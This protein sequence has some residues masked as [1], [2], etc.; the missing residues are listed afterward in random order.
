MLGMKLFASGLLWVFLAGASLSAVAQSQNPSL[1]SAVA[2]RQVNVVP[3]LSGEPDLVTGVVR[4]TASST[5][6]YS[7]MCGIA[8]QNGASRESV[9]WFADIVDM[10][11][12]KLLAPMNRHAY[13]AVDMLQVE[14]L[15]YVQPSRLA[16]QQDKLVRLC[17]VLRYFL[18]G[19]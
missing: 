19:R 12:V 9:Q 13:E 5:P 1:N 14:P 8:K 15:R 2:M 3:G 4:D 10:K 6:V 11:R 17:D 7:G 18:D 16:K